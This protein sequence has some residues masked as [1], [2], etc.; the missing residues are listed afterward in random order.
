MGFSG[1]AG[2]GAVSSAEVLSVRDKLQMGGID[3][4]GDAAKVVGL[5][6]LGDRPNQQLMADPMSKGDLT[7]IPGHPET[8]IAVGVLPAGPEPAG[9]GLV[10]VGPEAISERCG[11]SSHNTQGRES[12]VMCQMT[13]NGRTGY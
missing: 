3:T 11:R 13:V 10:D 5:Q 6:P 9:I 12:G 2:A 7:R 1:V 8:A 4:S